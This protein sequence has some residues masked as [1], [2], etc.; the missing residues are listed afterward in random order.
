MTLGYYDDMIRQDWDAEENVH[1]DIGKHFYAELG[2]K[3]MLMHATVPGHV[4]KPLFGMPFEGQP[5][6]LVVVAY[7]CIV[8]I[9]CVIRDKMFEFGHWPS[10][11][12]CVF[13]MGK[14]MYHQPLIV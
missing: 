12:E 11:V 13:F 14:D 9:C 6:D 3:N 2:I 1:A 5:S 7:I 8:N 10:R 4:G